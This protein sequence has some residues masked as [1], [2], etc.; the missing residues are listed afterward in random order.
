MELLAENLEAILRKGNSSLNQ[1]LEE[2]EV[3]K[4]EHLTLGTLELFCYRNDIDFVNLLS[5]KMNVDPQ[6]A[7]RIK[8]LILDVDGV[9]TDAGMFF[10]ENGDQI[11][12]YNAKDGMAIMALKKSGVDVGIISSGFKLEMVKARAELLRIEHLY[13]GRDPKIDILKGWCEKL[14]INLSEVGII[15][16]DINDLQVMKSV[17]FSA[18]PSDAVPVV[19]ANVDLVLNSKGGRGC[20]REFIDHY[21]LDEPLQG[22]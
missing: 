16:D 22:H 6:K 20:V 19:K 4:V 8:L 14:N 17:G 2:N 9:M 1:Y 7:K 11:K 13:V 5:Y 3:S 15:G 21:L 18:A 10:T 12:K